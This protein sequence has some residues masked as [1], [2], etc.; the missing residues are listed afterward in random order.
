MHISS[1]LHCL[2]GQCDSP[3]DVQK[4][5][6]KKDKK[7]AANESQA[8]EIASSQTLSPRS[9][10]ANDIPVYDP[11][12]TPL[13]CAPN[14]HVYCAYGHSLPTERGYFYKHKPPSLEPEQ[15]PSGSLAAASR[16]TL[17]QACLLRP[18]CVW[19]AQES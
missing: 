14:L 9:I 15:C 3:G 13:P 17:G 18:V 2:P 7:R 12:T 4:C 5:R 10:M 11:L 6:T 1:W 8:G 19:L 16:L